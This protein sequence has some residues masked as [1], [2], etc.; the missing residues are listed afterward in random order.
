MLLLVGVDMGKKN[1]IKQ[2]KK[3]F[4]LPEDLDRRLKDYIEQTP[5]KSTTKVIVEALKLLLR[6][7]GFML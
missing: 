1:G 7:K 5:E 6:D 3:S 4:N 2:V